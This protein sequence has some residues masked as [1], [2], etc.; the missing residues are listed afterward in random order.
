MKMVKE[1]QFCFLGLNYKN[2]GLDIRDKTSFTDSR[3]IDFL[4]KIE[5]YGIDQCMIL[6]TC[7]R[8]EVYFFYNEQEQV[9]I[10]RRAYI[11]FFDKVDV[12]KYLIMYKKEK[13]MEYLFRVTAGLESQVLGEDQILGQVKEALDFSRTMG[14]TKKEMNKLVRDAISCAKKI[15][16]DFK[17]SEIPLSVSYIG[18]RYLEEAAGLS[19]KKVLVIGSGKMSALALRYLYEYGA[20]QV[21]L[22]SRTVTHAKALQKDF[23]EIKVVDYNMR[24]QVLEECDVVISA[25]ASPHTV[26]KKSESNIRNELYLLDLAAPRDIDISFMHDERCHL[27]NLDT[28][29]RISEENRKEKEE[30]A[31]KCQDFILQELEETRKWFMISRMDETI[32]S[33]QQR[34]SEIVDDSFG[35]LDRKLELGEREKTILRKTLNASLQRLM[36]EPIQELKQLDTKEKQDHYKEVVCKLFQI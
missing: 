15:K 11:S 16:S 12:E 3:K 34:C 14:Y 18:I 6:S 35:Y 13:A 31:R 4:Q 24:Y 36:K 26:L 10:V 8:S 25:T 2:T 20:A 30:I 21:F 29:R 27:I 19:G 32:E 33:L 9:E 28:L 5:E 17:I 22:C 1:M 23:P 7:N